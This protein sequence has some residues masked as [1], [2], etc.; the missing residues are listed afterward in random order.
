[1]A[2]AIWATAW[3]VAAWAQGPS[4]TTSRATTI[5]ADSRILLTLGGAAIDPL[6]G[7]DYG[8]GPVLI[9]AISV[10]LVPPLHVE[11]EFTRRSTERNYVTD[12]AFFYAGPTGI[13]GHAD[14]TIFGTAT[15]D[16]T[17]A[18]NVIGR[19][20]SRLITAFGGGGLLLHTEH[21]RE[22]HRV[23]N[24]TPPIPAN[25]FECTPFDDVSKASSFGLQ[26]L[27]GVDIRITNRVA[28]FAGARYEIRKGLSLGG[29]GVTAGVRVTL[30]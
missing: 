15:T 27:G 12:K 19:S 28:G 2:M 22:Y 4:G 10:A 6:H 25:G 8:E 16:W 29:F 9:G 20:R 24:C 11:F 30:R 1:M 23:V 26:A 17:G 13:P 18:V 7:D 5:Q 21:R 14:R 3:P